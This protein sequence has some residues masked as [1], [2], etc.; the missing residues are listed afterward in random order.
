MIKSDPGDQVFRRSIFALIAAVLIALLGA[1]NANAATGHPRLQR[2]AQ[3][4]ISLMLRTFD[5]NHW[6]AP[7][8]CADSEVTKSVFLLPTLL[9]PSNPVPLTSQT[10]TC[11][12]KAHS[13]LVDLGGLIVAEDNSG[14]FDRGTLAETCDRFLPDFFQTPLPLTVD[15]QPASIAQSVSTPEFIVTGVN[16]ASGPNYYG[17]SQALNHPGELAVAYCG[18]KA[19]VKLHKGVHQISI[20]LSSL[21]EG[22]VFTYNIT[23]T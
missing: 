20:D 14:N 17:A 3:A 2:L 7:A 19:E 16:P 1:A 18:F 6:S 21:S 11:N 23:A 10:F 15:G 4:Q 12:T 8:T 22:V 13:V 9:F 5:D